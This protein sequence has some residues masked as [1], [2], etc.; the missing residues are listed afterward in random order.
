MHLE[1]QVEASN[2]THC[3]AVPGCLWHPHALILLFPCWWT[4]FVLYRGVATGLTL[5]WVPGRLPAAL[6]STAFSQIPPL[7][8]QHLHLIL[9]CM[10]SYICLHPFY[11]EI[12]MLST[13]ELSPLG[14]PTALLF[15]TCPW[16]Q[17]F[18]LVLVVNASII[19]HMAKTEFPWDQ[20]RNSAF[21]IYTSL[22]RPVN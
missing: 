11:Q 21:P 6:L 3:S 20:N 22:L 15:V 12:S 10:T 1:W 13:S 16:Y 4:E 14:V 17:W 9:W 5:S 2:R 8:H 18:S 19:Q 7:E